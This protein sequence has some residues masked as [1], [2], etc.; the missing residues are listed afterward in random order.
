MLGAQEV[1]KRVVWECPSKIT[2]EQKQEEMRDQILWLSGERTFCLA[3][4]RIMIGMPEK[5]QE[6]HS[7]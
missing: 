2:L 4:D 7:G 1:Y 5:S 6:D 3:R